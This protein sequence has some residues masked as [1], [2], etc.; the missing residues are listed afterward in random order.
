MA[1]SRLSVLVLVLLAAG[2]AGADTRQAGADVTFYEREADIGGEFELIAQLEVSE[3]TA[4]YGAAGPVAQ[5][6][7]QAAQ[8]GANGVLAVSDP[9][10]VADSRIRAAL[11]IQSS[12]A[13]TRYFAIYVRRAGD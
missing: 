6:K 8:F 4:G 11:D 3:R 7:A 2:C 1:L 10:D 12:Y 13:R 5:L 9:D